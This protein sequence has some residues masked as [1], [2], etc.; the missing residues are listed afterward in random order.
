MVFTFSDVESLIEL[1]GKN[2][3]MG[4]DGLE[5]EILVSGGDQVVFAVQSILSA[6]GKLFHAPTNWSGGR[7][8]N[9]YKGKNDA[10]IIFRTSG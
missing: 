6:A 8:I 4:P 3:C 10:E 9:Y 7:I 1:L 5:S 2:K